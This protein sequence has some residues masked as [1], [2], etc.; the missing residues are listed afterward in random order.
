MIAPKPL[1]IRI[2]GIDIGAHRVWER[3]SAA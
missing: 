2:R 3:I 1:P